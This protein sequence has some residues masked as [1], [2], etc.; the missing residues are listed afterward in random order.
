MAI[1]LDFIFLLLEVYLL[2]KTRRACE[3]ARMRTSLNSSPKNQA[4]CAFIS[5]S[6][7][8]TLRIE[9]SI[10]HTQTAQTI[11]AHLTP[12][13]TLHKHSPAINIFIWIH[14]SPPFS[15]ENFVENTAVH[16]NRLEIV[17]PSYQS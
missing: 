2:I 5:F 12:I 9:F 11:H 7:E 6:Y 8:I 3:N 10:S 17:L 1:V 15:R 16:W 4:G 13:S 14:I